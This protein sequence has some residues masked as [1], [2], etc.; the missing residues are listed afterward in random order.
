MAGKFSLNN[1]FGIDDEEQDEQDYEDTGTTDTTPTS[2]R[3]QKVV[4]I[5]SG[6]Q[7]TDYGKI[8]LLNHDCIP[9]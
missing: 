8:S 1:F 2:G 3:N 6:R 4:S 5:N 7:N 9:M